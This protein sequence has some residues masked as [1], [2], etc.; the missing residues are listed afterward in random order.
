MKVITRT[1][2]TLHCQYGQGTGLT[3]YMVPEGSDILQ[4]QT[5]QPNQQPIQD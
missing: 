4:K 1:S 5:N 2:P 3:S